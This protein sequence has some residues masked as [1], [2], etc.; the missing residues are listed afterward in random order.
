MIGIAHVLYYLSQI[1]SY[2]NFIS[3]DIYVSC[4]YSLYFIFFFLIV[5]SLYT[6]ISLYYIISPSIHVN[7]SYWLAQSPSPVYSSIQ[8]LLS[9]IRNTIILFILALY[10]EILFNINPDYHTYACAPI[11]HCVIRVLGVVVHFVLCWR[12]C[13]PTLSTCPSGF[14]RAQNAKTS[15]LVTEE[16]FE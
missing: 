3:V 6:D 7:H 1:Y 14:R 15:L 8:Q 11:M 5:K 13:N 10:I 2:H 12:L 16:W 4:V 9:T